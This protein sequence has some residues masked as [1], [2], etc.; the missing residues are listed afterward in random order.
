VN[1]PAKAKLADLLLG[2]G[3]VALIES[4]RAKKPQTSYETIAK[5]IWVGTGQQV[6]VTG[7][8]VQAWEDRLGITQPEQASA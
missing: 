2:G 3:L 7:V 5:L 4:E 6:S 1:L 8:T